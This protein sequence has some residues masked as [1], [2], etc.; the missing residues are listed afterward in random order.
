VA[1]LNDR[2]RS[3]GGVPRE[4]IT[5]AKSHDVY[6]KVS[7]AAGCD[8]RSRVHARRSPLTVRSRRRRCRRR[9]RRRR[10]HRRRRLREAYLGR[11]DVGDALVRI[12]LSLS[13]SLSR[14][15]LDCRLSSVNIALS[16]SFSF[17][18]HLSL[19]LSLSLFLKS[20]A[21]RRTSFRPGE[22]LSRAREKTVPSRISRMKTG[23]REGDVSLLYGAPRAA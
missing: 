6:T 11:R 19:S 2:R 12:S 1:A 4:P 15:P 3:D 9:R 18:V 5:L 16:L 13:L 20:L 8:S 7:Q 10:R 17:F 14:S 21:S 22:T 23:R